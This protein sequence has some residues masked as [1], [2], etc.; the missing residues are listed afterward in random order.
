MSVVCCRELYTVLQ[1]VVTTL[2]LIGEVDVVPL[3]RSRVI[4]GWGRGICVTVAGKARANG[5]AC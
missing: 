5:E 3:G 4:F 2:A 1:N